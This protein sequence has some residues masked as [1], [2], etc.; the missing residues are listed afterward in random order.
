MREPQDPGSRGLRW[1][2]GTLV[3]LVLGAVIQRY[4]DLLI[5]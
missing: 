3:V 4:A 2:G 5:T 1:W